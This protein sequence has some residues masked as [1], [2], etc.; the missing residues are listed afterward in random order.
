MDETKIIRKCIACGIEKS[1][2]KLIKITINKK[3]RTIE[4][5]PK[6]DFCG[7]SAYLCKDFECINN[8]FKK[9]RLYKI[10]KINQ[11]ES[12]KEKIMTV[13]ES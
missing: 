3:N 13:L 5:N 2:D 1:R 6:S 10:L 12:L 7:R 11:D 4:V 9:G 8:A